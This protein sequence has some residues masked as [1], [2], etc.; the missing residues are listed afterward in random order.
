MKKMILISIICV[1]SVLQASYKI[2]NGYNDDATK[3][4]FGAIDYN[5]IGRAQKAIAAGA[6]V[7]A[8]DFVNRSPLYVAAQNNALDLA[9]L[10]IAAGADVNGQDCN[11]QIPLHEVGVKNLYHI[12]KAS[13]LLGVDVKRLIVAK[14]EPLYIAVKEGSI[15]IVRLLLEQNAK[16]P[17]GLLNEEIAFLDKEIAKINQER[18]KQFEMISTLSALEAKE[19]QVNKKNMPA[20]LLERLTEMSSS[21][22]SL[23]PLPLASEV[24][25]QR[26]FI[27][28]QQ[29]IR[30]YPYAPWSKQEAGL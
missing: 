27:T 29:N 26:K 4:L 22:M 8:R 17:Y 10:L 11:M 28:N 21:H 20:G 18:A 14:R 3:D 7:N 2:H 16:I 30:D 15:L 25:V 6:D 5:N 1:Q 12:M 13:M 19:A 9:K 23:A 24:I